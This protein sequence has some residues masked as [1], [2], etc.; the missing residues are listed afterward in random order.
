MESN[1]LVNLWSHLA[2]SRAGDREKVTAVRAMELI[3]EFPGG[4]KH[5]K[6]LE[7]EVFLMKSQV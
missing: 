2:K 7:C 3:T 6:C 4:Q 5:G 1:Q